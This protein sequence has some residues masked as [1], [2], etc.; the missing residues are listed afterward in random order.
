MS[1]PWSALLSGVQ[2][3]YY[4]LTGMW[5][6]VDIASFQRVTGP[7]TDLWLVKTV[8]V[9]VTAIG[10]TLLLSALHH[11]AFLEI[12]LLAVS[13]ALGLAAIDLIYVRKKVISKIY[14]ADAVAELI[15]AAAWFLEP[16]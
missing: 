13:S 1:L 4:V 12:K 10:A 6:L 7:K 16:K 11:Q 9:C 14:A 8:G 15:L 5:A 2:G 3:G